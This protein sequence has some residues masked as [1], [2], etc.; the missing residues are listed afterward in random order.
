MSS[1]YAEHEAMVPT[2][3]ALQFNRFGIPITRAENLERTQSSLTQE[4]FAN[5]TAS[6]FGDYKV[7]TVNVNYIRDKQWK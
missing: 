1:R 5:E 3:P 2:L 6:R 4:K 7:N